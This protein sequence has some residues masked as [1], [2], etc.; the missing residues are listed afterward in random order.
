LANARNRISPR[1]RYGKIL[2]DAYSSFK[3]AESQLQDRILCIEA[4]WARTHQ[5]IKFLDRIWDSLDEEFKSL[6]ERILL[7]LL[8]K[9]QEAIAQI[10]RV[11]KKKNASDE[12]RNEA[13]GQMKK[14]K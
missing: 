5:Q 3:H 10:Q 11:L 14:Y 6:Q 2:V 8:T 7:N 12:H 1:D 13:N 9:L 4:N